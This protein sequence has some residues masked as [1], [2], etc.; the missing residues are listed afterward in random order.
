MQSVDAL[1]E[2]RDSR[3]WRSWMVARSRFDEAVGRTHWIA[4]THGTY[5]HQ[6][7]YI[8]LTR[9]LESHIVYKHHATE[10]VR[11]S[12][13]SSLSLCPVVARPSSARNVRPT[14]LEMKGLDGWMTQCPDSWWADCPG[15]SV[16]VAVRYDSPLNGLK[17]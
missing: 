2:A 7:M 15:T 11:L 14:L 4:Y 1:V 13:V 3:M 12:L 16:L 5:K 9:Q 8:D 17:S 10:Y 6:A